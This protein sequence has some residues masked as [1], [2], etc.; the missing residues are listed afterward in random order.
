MINGRMF[1]GGAWVDAAHGTTREIFN[2]AN[3]EIIATVADGSEEDADRA[4]EAARKAFDEGPWP[5]MRPQERASFL[6][7]LADLIDKNADELAALE[8]RNNG[9]PLREAR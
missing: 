1:I 2:P 7:R 8:T 9:K 3:N 5:Q 4:I 6:F